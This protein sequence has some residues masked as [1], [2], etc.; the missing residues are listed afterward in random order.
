[1]G[2]HTEMVM[3]G[4]LCQQCGAMVDDSLGEFPQDC[5][6][7]KEEKKKSD[8]NNSSKKNKSLTYCSLCKCE[9]PKAGK[10]HH[11]SG[12]RHQKNKAFKC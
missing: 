5:D 4:I 3:E 9:Y 6:D 7:C 11:I 12:K 1:M 8:A 2:E 10:N